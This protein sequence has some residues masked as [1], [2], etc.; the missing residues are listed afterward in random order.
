MREVIDLSDRVQITGSPITELEPASFEQIKE[1][2][3]GDWVVVE[4][5][6]GELVK[7]LREIDPR[8][9]VQHNRRT[10]VFALYTVEDTPEGEKQHLVNTFKKFDKR[11]VN[12]IRQI[13]SVEYDFIKEGED[14][15]KAKDKAF[16]VE[17]EEK[18]QARSE[19]LAYV[20]RRAFGFDKDH[21]YF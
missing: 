10:E 2:Q 6:V 12:R 16:E 11:V 14:L 13:Y 21:A 1:P 5:D 3:P 20:L 17:W 15:E 7:E 4:Q 18:V 9:R 8:L 19:E